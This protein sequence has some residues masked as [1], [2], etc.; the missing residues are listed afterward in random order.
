MIPNTVFWA[1]QDRCTLE[2][3]V[4][5]YALHKIRAVGTLVWGELRS[6]SICVS[7]QMREKETFSSVV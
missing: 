5:A 7:W 1:W 3:L 6:L 2:L 4:R